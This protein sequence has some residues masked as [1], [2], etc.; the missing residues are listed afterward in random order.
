MHSKA[1]SS[2]E[3][4]GK[5]W[6]ARFDDKSAPLITTAKQRS[7][8]KNVLLD[9]FSQVVPGTYSESKSTGILRAVTDVEKFQ[10]LIVEPLEYFLFGP[11][12]NYGHEWLRTFNAQPKF[13]NRLFN[14]ND[15]VF[16]CKYVFFTCIRSLFY[17]KHES[18]KHVHNE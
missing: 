14:V 18:I 17:D 13:C 12:S 2:G 4:I 7:E 10:K 3:T 11:K 5:K 15:P 9:Y 1:L 6:L 16:T 8:M